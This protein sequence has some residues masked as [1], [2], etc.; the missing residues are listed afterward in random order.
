MTQDLDTRHGR[1][2]ACAGSIPHADTHA[3]SAEYAP[4]VYAAL[5]AA[6]R[7]GMMID[8]R[9]DAG[10]ILVSPSASWDADTPDDDILAVVRAAA[11]DR[12]TEWAEFVALEAAIEAA[13]E[14]WIAA[15]DS[16]A[17]QRK[18]V[19]DAWVAAARGE[20]SR[21]DA[22]LRMA[23]RAEREWGDSPLYGPIVA[24]LDE[25]AG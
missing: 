6:S 16:A 5:L 14:Y 9:H 4:T 1:A 8:W 17:S 25:A 19:E 2:D 24:M 12:P 15:R 3:R 20:W 7:D 23:E 21:V 18:A 11:G 22:Y 13:A 10:G